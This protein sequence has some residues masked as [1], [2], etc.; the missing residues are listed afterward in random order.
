MI[1][2]RFTSA[3]FCALMIIPILGTALPG[4]NL[5]ANPG[6]ENDPIVPLN[7][8]IV[9]YDGNTPI[10]DSESHNGA[11]AIKI[12]VKGTSDAISGFVESD[13]I[14]V[15]PF[16]YF[17]L[18]A[19]GKT[20]GAG[21]TYMPRVRVIELDANKNLVLQTNLPEFNGS[22]NDWT[23]TS[24]KFQ[25]EHDTAYLYVYANIWYGYGTFWVDDVELKQ[26]NIDPDLSSIPSGNS[27]PTIASIPQPEQPP[28]QSE[29][30]LV[31]DPGFE[32][33]EGVP[34]NWTFVT[35]NGNTP[36]LDSESHNGANAI[37]ISVE[38][39]IDFISGDV[40]SDLIPSGPHQS[41]NFSAWG[42]TEN[43]DGTYTPRVRIVELDAKRNWLIQTNLPEFGRG[44]NDWEQRSMQFETQSRTAYLYIYANIWNGYGIFRVDDIELRKTMPSPGITPTPS[45]NYIP[46]PTNT[47]LAANPGFE[48]GDSVPFNWTFVTQNGNEPIWGNESHSGT[49]AI[50]ISIDGTSNAISGYVMSDLIPVEPSQNFDFSAWGRTEGIGGTSKPVVRIVE[51]GANEDWLRQTRLPEFGGGTNDWTKKSVQFLTGPDTAYLYI[52]ANIWKGY[53]TFWIDDVEL[54]RKSDYSDPTPVPDTTTTITSPTLTYT[55]YTSPFNPTGS[56][57]VNVNSDKTLSINGKKVFPQ[58]FITICKNTISGE[59]CNKNLNKMRIYTADMVGYG[60]RSSDLPSYVS[61][62]VGVMPMVDH[63]PVNSPA[64]FGYYQEDE[65]ELPEHEQFKKIYNNIKAK[66]PNHIVLT[67]V[68]HDGI[69]WEDTADVIWFGLYP[70]KD[71][72]WINDMGPREMTLYKYEYIV[73]TNILLGTKDFDTTNK[74]FWPVLQALSAPD[75][76]RALPTTK[77]ETR[78]LI[79]TAITM[80]VKGLAYWSYSWTP[81]DAGLWKNQKKVD[82]HISIA[83][84]INYLD[85]ILLLPTKDYSW[86]GHSGTSVSLTP[87][88][89]KEVE[90]NSIKAFSYILKQQG[91]TWYLIVVNKD[92][93]PI[94]N[95][96]IA[97]DGLTGEMSVKTLGLETEGSEAAGRTLI[98]NNGRFTDSFDGY[99]AHIYRIS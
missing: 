61:N 92:S 72:E 58:V 22:T 83:N 69:R 64:L 66:D 27:T 10:M 81:N 44:T 67:G 38:G 42:K 90:G 89:V 70:Y 1:L 46:V 25:T 52:K 23:Q 65:P 28:L 56:S 68:W 60:Y 71:A 9:S 37:K 93:N 57:I 2:I 86:Y 62:G 51:V 82:E 76:A 63:F 54:S 32:N 6:F 17:N 59:Q 3:I 21:G 94:N 39:T 5:V 36:T 41:Y 91:N 11:N 19:W 31:S 75:D 80:N 55:S 16:Q 98:A 14:P 73:K 49:N 18:S 26:L 34:L 47:N 88:P 8:T 30:N 50:K 13:L 87:N 29:E 85:D 79:Y 4:V 12:S 95:V 77:E 15:E 78:A 53:G 20:E 24:I 96:N 45:I 33:G 48:K 74:P 35:L 40:M 99:A 97:I 7:W 84:E 43:V